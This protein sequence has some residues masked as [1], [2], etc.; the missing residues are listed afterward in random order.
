ME[1]EGALNDDPDGD[2]PGDG[3]VIVDEDEGEE[4]GE[5]DDRRVV[6]HVGGDEGGVDGENEYVEENDEG[7]DVDDV[8]VNGKSGL[9]CVR[10]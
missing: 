2:D 8:V 4:R 7:G 10:G 5:G 6:G 3:N 9:I 1:K